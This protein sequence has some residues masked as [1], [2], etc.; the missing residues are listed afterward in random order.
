MARAAAR[1]MKLRSVRIVGWDEFSQTCVS[2]PEEAESDPG[3]A[4]AGDDF[5]SNDGED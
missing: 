5:G 2:K 3:A 4:S 1:R